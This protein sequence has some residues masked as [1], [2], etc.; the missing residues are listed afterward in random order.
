MKKILNYFLIVLKAVAQFLHFPL[1]SE[2][3]IGVIAIL[4]YVFQHRFWGVV[5][6][7]WGI[8]LLINALNKPKA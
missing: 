8:L 1:A 7:V 3:T 4:L 6:L 5:L 2:I